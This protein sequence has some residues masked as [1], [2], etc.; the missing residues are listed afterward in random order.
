MLRDTYKYLRKM[1]GIVEKLKITS[2][3]TDTVERTYESNDTINEKR[4]F[5][6]LLQVVNI[7]IFISKQPGMFPLRVEPL[8]YNVS[9]Y[10]QFVRVR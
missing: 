7:E 3:T 8:L 9:F 10:A 5:S 6:A 4:M 1:F 2:K